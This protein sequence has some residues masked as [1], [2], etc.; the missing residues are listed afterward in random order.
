MYSEILSRIKTEKELREI[1]EEIE[2]LMESLYKTG[3]DTLDKV[4][5]TKIKGWLAEEIKK[6]F[7]KGGNKES[8]LENLKKELEEMDSVR[9]TLG[10]EPSLEVL[11][12]IHTWLSNNLKKNIVM[13]L[14][15]NPSIIGGV[16]IAYEGKYRDFSLRKELIN[17]F[18]EDKQVLIERLNQAG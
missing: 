18:K 4:L 13:D 7:E 8:Y 2:V 5:N 14:T 3:G 12:N 15:F 1:E 10:F 9:I 11:E 17:Y 6:A 16:I